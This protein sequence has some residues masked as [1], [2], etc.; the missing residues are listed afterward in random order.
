MAKREPFEMGRQSKDPEVRAA[1]AFLDDLRWRDLL[2]PFTQIAERHGALLTEMF[3]RSRVQHIAA[4]RHSAWRYLRD[5]GWSYPAIAGLFKVH[6]TTV[7]QSFGR[8]RAQRVENLLASAGS[9]RDAAA[10]R[11]TN[12]GTIPG[13]PAASVASIC[14]QAV[15]E[16]V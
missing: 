9:V 4:A 16:A 15:A 8:T 1:M 14:G 12:V 13:Q 5:T 10:N 11:A 7:M 2:E 3:G 6:H